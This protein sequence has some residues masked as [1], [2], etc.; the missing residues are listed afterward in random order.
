MTRNKKSSPAEDIVQIVTVLPWWAGIALAIILYF[1]LHSMALA[2]LATTAG[3][4]AQVGQLLVGTLKKTLAGIGQ[5]LLPFLCLIGAAASVLRRG[6][7]TQL[8]NN[9]IT[10]PSA[11]KGMSWQEFE[12][13]V[14]EVFRLRG[15]SVQ[16]NGG[17]GADGGVDL[18]LKKN[19]E[20]FLV[21][22]KQWRSLKVGVTVIRELYGVMAADGA[23]GG[24]VVTCGRFTEEAKSFA[25]GRNLTLL[26]GEALEKLIRQ[27]QSEASAY[28]M[29]VPPPVNSSNA[30]PGCPVCG[31]LMIS[32]TAQRGAN[33]GRRF[34]GCSAYPSCRGT[35][36]VD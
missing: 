20:K 1:V 16:E 29:A 31:K 24:F 5:Y 34:W 3:N 6:A 10:S 35:A 14:G 33:A 19:G 25:K 32:R 12:Q 15:Y 11:L 36:A 26:D 7:R 30:A 22:C 21:Q 9:V 17:G 18:V 27:T 8:I 2:P 13:L 4:P 28:S 23:V